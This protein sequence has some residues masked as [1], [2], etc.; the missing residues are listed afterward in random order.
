M[1][2]Q[3]HVFAVKERKQAMPDGIPTRREH[4]GLYIICYNSEGKTKK[5]R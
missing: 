1:A 2:N 3:L 5:Q 4:R